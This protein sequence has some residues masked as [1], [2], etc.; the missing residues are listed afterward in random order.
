[1]QAI[2]RFFESYLG[3]SPSGPGQGT[4]WRLEARLPTTEGWPAVLLGVFI[5]IVVVGVVLLYFHEARR[6][7]ITRR[8]TL[9]GLRLLALAIIVVML[10][11]ITLAVDRTGLP[12]L[13]VLID[14]SASMGL[15]EGNRGR[16]QQSPSR[17]FDLVRDALSQDD[18]RL[19]RNL[20]KRFRLRAYSFAGDAAAVPTNDDGDKVQELV[21]AINDL[22]PTGDET[23][24]AAAVRRVLDELRGVSPG[25]IVVFTDGASTAGEAEALSAVAETAARRR[26]PL[27]PV[28]VGS[29]GPSRDLELYELV[30][31]DVAF[32]GDP[33]RV[34][35]RMRSFGMGKQRVTVRLLDS[36]T[37]ELLAEATT[38]P[39]ADGQP[40]E[41]E[42][43]FT[44][45]SEGGRDVAVK[46]SVAGPESNTSN[47]SMSRHIEVRK[48]KIRVLLA[49]HAPRYEYRFLKSLLEREP[50]IELDAVLQEA[51][52]E[53]SAEDRTALDRF[54]IR[55]EEILKY[56]VIIFGD[57]DPG[58]LGSDVLTALVE[59]VRVKGGGIIGVAGPEFFPLRYAGTPLETM[60]PIQLTDA[61]APP[62]DALL[63]EPFRPEL[64]LQGRQAGPMFRLEG[65]D[66]RSQA[67]W[68][69]LPGLYWR[70]DAPTLR[71]GAI[72]MAQAPDL[73]GRQTPVIAMQRFGAG[74][75]LLHLS[76]ETWR[77]RW[78]AGDLYFGRYWIQAIRFL[79][80]ASLVGSQNG[81]E[82][83]ADRRSY[84]Q[85][86]DVTLRA[87][88]L[89]ERLLP[90]SPQAVSVVVEER[91]GGRQQIEFARAGELS[92]VF[93]GRLSRLPEG[94]YHAWVREPVFAGTPPAVDFRVEA[95][96]RELGRRAADI[97]DLRRAAEKSG[98]KY[99]DLKDVAA[100][101][102]Q[103]PAGRSV[104]LEAAEPRPLWNRPELMLM[105]AAVL[106]AEWLLRKQG[107]LA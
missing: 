35:A 53:Y 42:L 7:S 6:L 22:A 21:A 45:Q 16:D 94:T 38:N 78:R 14:R 43:A 93:E 76:D 65:D 68:D 92:N 44:P 96:D 75:V 30:A 60:L 20:E 27:Y 28:G 59:F 72:A 32:L 104:R 87:R 51:D 91:S 62:N 101:P 69:S 47:N 70:I 58:L 90:P 79:S 84:S 54:P 33:V 19:L 57:L 80:R 71:A 9:A 100:L 13:A 49:D 50:T 86:D 10:S 77:W 15:P 106:S 88:F 66:E 97:A 46:I 4:A 37:G 31:D 82:L 39:T 56:D 83:T 67:V 17:R 2:K 81:A 105:L 63:A 12:I 48:Q 25:A 64:T 89:D 107:R 23:R 95:P 29:D 3:I 26:V 55:K 102:R 85:G 103:L 74:K 41:Q 18:G 61:T 98:G 36:A 52:L 73:A 5:A 1:M 24:P 8:L 99:Y 34:T 40:F 11:Q